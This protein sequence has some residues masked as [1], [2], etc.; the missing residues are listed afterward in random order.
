MEIPSTNFLLTW[1][2]Y[3]KPWKS[4]LFGSP[5]WHC[6]NA[7]YYLASATVKDGTILSTVVFIRRDYALRMNPH[8]KWLEDNKPEWVAKFEVNPRQISSVSRFLD[9]LPAHF[10]EEIN[11]MRFNRWIERIVFV[12]MMR[13]GTELYQ[14]EETIPRTHRTS[15]LLNLPHDFKMH[16][17]E[18]IKFTKQS[19]SS[20]YSHA[21]PA[22]PES[23]KM[24]YYE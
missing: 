16:E 24:C 9:R 13:E 18:F 5:G 19:P 21:I 20:D 7:S 10:L 17:V 4:I 23:M 1:R 15:N 14:E 3:E 22:N 12:L 2:P 6:I 8:L 11:E